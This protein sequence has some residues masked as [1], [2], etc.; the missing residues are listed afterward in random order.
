MNDYRLIYLW[1]E[2][3][4]N[5]KNKGIYFTLDYNVNIDQNYIDATL[6][7]FGRSSQKNNNPLSV[8]DS[9]SAIV[10]PNGSGKSNVLELLKHIVCLHKFPSGE[11]EASG[12]LI[13]EQK[14]LDGNT[15]LCMITNSDAYT[16][17]VGKVTKYIDFK[18]KKAIYYNP[19]DDTYKPQD[20]IINGDKLFRIGDNPVGN[21]YSNTST[22]HN[23]KQFASFKDGLEEYE[24][25]VKT[26]EN[27]HACYVLQYQEIKNRVNSILI[28]L[29]IGKNRIS[30]K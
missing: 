22:T 27:S 3:Y 29:G 25:F 16:F 26:F 15:Q 5:V 2:S 8:L 13:I 6:N 28:S 30:Y 9:F 21:K 12:F 19:I 7:D 4:K 11:N 17:K 10:G 18:T 1:I 23:I 24:I 20:I 14:E